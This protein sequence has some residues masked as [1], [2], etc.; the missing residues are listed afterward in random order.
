MLADVTNTMPLQKSIMKKKI[1]LLSTTF[2]KKKIYLQFIIK[3]MAWEIKDVSH[4]SKGR[5]M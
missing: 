2:Y 1:A 5:D 4:Y 3:K